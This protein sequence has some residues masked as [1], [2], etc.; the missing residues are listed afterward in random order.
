MSNYDFVKVLLFF[1]LQRAAGQQWWPERMFRLY[2]G[3]PG[4]EGPQPGLDKFHHKEE[5]QRLDQLGP[6]AHHHCQDH[7]TQITEFE[8]TG[9][10]VP[11]GLG[12]R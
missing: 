9:G 6:L 3:P 1:R 5:P 4:R 7:Q 10:Q 8:H 11:V 2:F 12:A